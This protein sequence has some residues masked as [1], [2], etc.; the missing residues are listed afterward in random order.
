MHRVAPYGILFAVA[1][2]L[3]AVVP[4]LGTLALVAAAVLTV[5]AALRRVERVQMLAWAS[6]LVWACLAALIWHF[7][8]DHFYVRQVWLYSGSGL[9]LHLKLVGV[10]GTDEG[11]TLLLAALLTTLAARA[12]RVEP[13]PQPTTPGAAAVG[14]AIAAWY[15]LLALWLMPF[16]ATPAS[17]LAQAPYQGMNAHLQKFWMVVHPPLVMLAYA[18]C[19]VLAAPALAAL[20]GA[21]SSWPTWSRV[22]ARRTWV[23]L[24]AGIGFGMVWA[25]EDAMYGQVWH[26]DPVQTAIFCLWCFLSAHLHGVVGWKFGRRSDWLMPWAGLL[27]ALMVPLV[28]AITRNPLLASSHRYVDAGSWK[29]HLALASVLLLAGGI[30]SFVGYRR[31]RATR[32][33]RQTRRRASDWGLW[34]T[35]LAFLLAGL[36]AAAQL[37]WAFGAEAYGV[38]RPDRY[39]PF[40]AMVAKLTSGSQLDSLRR[41][42]DQWDVDGYIVAQLLLL[43]LAVLGLVG[44]WYF[45]RR[46][47]RRA[48]RVSL[49]MVAV[50]V[51]LNAVAG[52]ALTHG[53]GGDGILSQNIVKVL[54]LFDAT[55][56]AGGYLALAC[57]A[58]AVGASRKAGWRGAATAMPLGF[59]H[60]GVVIMFF[61]GMV[62]I[63]LNGYSQHELILDGAQTPWVQ[64]PRGYAFRLAD[65]QLSSSAGDGGWQDVQGIRAVTTVQVVGPDGRVRDGQTLYRDSRAPSERFNGPVR[66]MCEFLD[67]RY[68][69]HVM[70]PGYLLDPLIDQGWARSVQFWISP[71]DILGV[72]GASTASGKVVAV[73]KVFPLMSLL[74]LGLA[75][76]L[77]GGA[78]MAFGPRRQK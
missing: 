78:W 60:A 19:L 56:V 31:R 15:V 52:G 23:L 74:W 42:F 30:A 1:A 66:Q 50:V 49:V 36:A 77:C 27:A 45:L 43:P 55:L 4:T 53:Y 10:L 21:E 3:A 9:P 75:V 65:M 62:A 37:A 73:V 46:I 22:W 17:W 71:A 28:M 44:G 14:A 72:T 70:T 25:F 16:A 57:L 51:V 24:S 35:Q 76:T 34:L 54:P 58:W 69:R 40:F 48:G 47:S 32:R 67:Y 41:A 64:S 8:A 11:A 12:A 2:I 61:G 13:V 26:W 33:P 5:A 20:M 18:G 6:A 29:A 59:I 63:G 7:A 38:P 39:K 68:A